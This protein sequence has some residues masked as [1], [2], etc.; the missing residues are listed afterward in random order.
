M[1]RARMLAGEVPMVK[2]FSQVGA[3][4]ETVT[5]A[6]AAIVAVAAKTAA[7]FQPCGCW[8]FK[9]ILRRPPALS[10]PP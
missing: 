2:V 8:L 6:T 10:T 4:W 9:A 1:P 5:T 7:R 3:A